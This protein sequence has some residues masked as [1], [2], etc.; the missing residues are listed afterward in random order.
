MSV[1][2]SMAYNNSMW[3]VEEHAIWGHIQSRVHDGAYKQVSTQT[4]GQVTHLLT[5]HVVRMVDHRVYYVVYVGVT[6]E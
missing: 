5:T 6:E 3:E 1:R 2:E 4:R